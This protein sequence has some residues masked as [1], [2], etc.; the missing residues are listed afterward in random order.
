[1]ADDCES[2]SF[3]LLLRRRPVGYLWAS[4]C[5]VVRAKWLRVVGR[6]RGGVVSRRLFS[7]PLP[8]V[9][10]EGLG[11]ETRNSSG[12]ARGLWE[13]VDRAVVVGIVAV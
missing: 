8:R 5:I 1:M 3:S 11:D 2:W 10:Q 13:F 6:V 9:F 12:C 7:S 4:R